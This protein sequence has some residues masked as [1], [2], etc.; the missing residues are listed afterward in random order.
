LKQDKLD[1]ALLHFERAVALNPNYAA[2]HN[3]KGLVLKD[4][5][6]FDEAEK[7]FRRALELEP[8]YAEAHNN[9]A[10]VL[11]NLGR[12]D[13]A[14][15]HGE[16]A[17]ALK[18]NYPEAL[19]NLGNVRRDQKRF[20]EAIALFERALALKP[21]FAEVHSNLGNVFKDQDQMDAAAD[22]YEKALVLKPNYAEGHFN[23]GIVRQDQGKYDEALTHY[24]R[25]QEL[26]PNFNDA[27]WNESLLLLLKGDFENGWRQYE[28]R[29]R[30]KNA[31]SHCFTAPLW[32][33]GDLS[34][35]TILLH[36]EQGFGDSLQ[37]VRYVPMVKE[38]GGK[39]LLICQPALF[40]LFKDVAGFDQLI[41]EGHAVPPH[42]CQAP[43]LSL[44]W[45][46][47]TTLTTVPNKIPYV[48][49]PSDKIALWAE[50]LRPYA[51]RKIGLLWAGSPRNNYP[52]AHAIDKR[53]SMRLEQFAPLATVPGVHFFS[54]Q[55]GGPAT[56]AKTPPP[57]MAFT[58]FMDHVEDFTDTAALIA[59]LDLVI[60]VDT[61][62]IHLAGAL[63]KPVWALSR[64]D[65]C[66]RWLLNRGDSPWYPTMS[67][68]RQPKPWDWESVIEKVREALVVWVA[69][70]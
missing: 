51:G 30:K 36:C 46:L 8:D 63:A 25:A 55:K 45:L 58:D 59:N 33:G 16:R 1:E 13:E 64:Y 37:F 11:R 19:S 65:G 70:P 28:W 62:V 60:G 3:N 49:A 48:A 34:G 53:R 5:D 24:K 69:G 67:L 17:I 44:P 29:W 4:K 38:R 10:F 23:L 42:D 40:T 26:K 54:L 61:A 43:L 57:G 14:S 47:K 41:P 35:K 68:F 39:V 52:E 22:C 20:D 56:Q 50:R 31:D 6:K 21:A 2:A 9:L 18:P 66:W 12:L 32:D 7:Y 27:Y 15:S